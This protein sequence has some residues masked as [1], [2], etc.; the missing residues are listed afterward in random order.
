M[1]IFR[2]GLDSL[3]VA[4]MGRLSKKAL[5]ELERV[6]ELAKE[7]GEPELFTFGQVKG[8]V[9]PFGIGKQGYRYM[10]NTGDDK[11]TWKFKCS[12]DPQQW[13]I[14]VEVRAIQLAT[15][16]YF[17]IKQRLFD[18]L[19][20]LGAITLEE[21]IN[22]V[23]IACDF[24]CED[25]EQPDP[26]KFVCHSH[27]TVCTHYD[28]DTETEGFHVVGGRKKSS[29]TVGRLPGRQVQIYDKRKEAIYKKKDYWFEIWG[30]EKEECSQMWRIETRFGKKYLYDQNV[31]T[32]DDLEEHMQRMVDKC[33]NDIRMV[34]EVDEQNV[35]RSIPSHIWETAKAKIEGVFRFGSALA[36]PVRV[37]R[38]AKEQYNDMLGS[39]IKGLA[40]TL[41]ASEGVS[42][43]ECLALLPERVSK[44]I[45]DFMREENDKF[46]DKYKRSN[47]R[48][49]WCQFAGE[50]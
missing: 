2:V 46:R 25:F 15:V 10:L 19:K 23:D 13:N 37:L 48:L 20:E 14:F 3:Y 36:N 42:L 34:E 30:I 41:A 29:V 21:S 9:S 31:R 50:V 49:A 4:F 38:V 6:R 8:L 1:K 39:Q 35:T 33:L 27:S 12:D 28:E 11:E 5:R 18:T 40:V 43:G 7:T 22:R 24:Q 44:L 26:E 45:S 17:E 32:F 16:D 47:N